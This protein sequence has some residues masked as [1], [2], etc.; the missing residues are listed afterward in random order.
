[1]E[2]QCLLVTPEPVKS[3]APRTV[4]AFD[5]DAM[6]LSRMHGSIGPQKR[7]PQDDKT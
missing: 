6:L 2:E 7:G 5:A 1:M 3:F 4:Y